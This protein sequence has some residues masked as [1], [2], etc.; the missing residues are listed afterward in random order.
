MFVGGE[1]FPPELLK[2]ARAAKATGQPQPVKLR[3]LLA[4][5]GALRRGY[6]V[7]NQ[8]REGL[9]TLGLSTRPDFEN[10]WIDSNI[11]LV[12]INGQMPITEAIGSTSGESSASAI[13][14]VQTIPVPFVGTVGA[15]PTY[16]IGQLP[17]ANQSLVSV[18]PSSTITEAATQMLMHDYSQLPIMHHEREV[19]GMVTW[20]SIGEK[21]VLESTCSAVQHCQVPHR[22]VSADS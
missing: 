7:N 21:Y 19:K 14:E 8:V 4:M 6:R 17:A 5:F 22:E 18:K 9:A 16:R 2:L 13:G 15:D 11:E 3:D 12:P 20:A 10:E 1:Y